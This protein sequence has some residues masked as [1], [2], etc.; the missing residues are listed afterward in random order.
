MFI[1]LGI[2]LGIIT[3][4]SQNRF[5]FYPFVYSGI[6][7]PS[8]IVEIILAKNSGRNIELANILL[9]IL[10]ITVTVSILRMQ[11]PKELRRKL[12]S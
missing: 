7:L 1:P 11:I 4:L 2:L 12:I 8:L 6:L 10:M 3:T 9:G 5:V